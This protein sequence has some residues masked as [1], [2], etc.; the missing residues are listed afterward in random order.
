MDKGVCCCL[1]VEELV[2]FKFSVLQESH[3]DPL[4]G[5]DEAGGMGT[6]PAAG[7][8]LIVAFNNE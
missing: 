1:R 8:G 4:L 3:H 7:R 6:K 5:M 2:I